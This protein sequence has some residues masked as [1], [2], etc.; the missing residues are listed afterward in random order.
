MGEE[1]SFQYL[2]ESDGT[3]ILPIVIDAEYPREGQGYK[4][5][6]SEYSRRIKRHCPRAE[7]SPPV[8]I[9]SINNANNPAEADQVAS[10]LVRAALKDFMGGETQVTHRVIAARMDIFKLRLRSVL[11]RFFERVEPHYHRL[12]GAEDAAVVKV[13]KQLLGSENTLRAGVRMRL[14]METVRPVPV[15]YFPYRILLTGMA[16]AAGAIDRLILAFSG[17]LPSLAIT[18][19]QT[20]RNLKHLHEMRANARTALRERAGEMVREELSE[21]NEIFLRSIEQE[22][23]LGERSRI[24][25]AASQ[26]ELSGLGLVESRSTDIFEQSFSRHAVGRWLPWLLGGMATLAFLGLAAAPAWSIYHEFFK[27]WQASFRDANPAI[28]QDFPAPSGSMIFAT[29]LLMTV[30]VIFIALITVVLSATPRRVNRCVNAIIGA[31]EQ[32]QDDLLR[33]RA[34][35]V[36]TT[37]PVRE[38]VRTLLDA[39]PTPQD[40]SQG[41][42]HEIDEGIPEN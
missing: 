31:H 4:D 30:P 1:S 35:R 16:L 23:D 13:I 29:L 11:G 41:Y 15:I 9:P 33:T 28:W 8:V 20:S 27:A 10:E 18:A 36:T 24:R 34:L 7:V 39:C 25:G 17:N 21:T 12:Q 14:L 2:S 38:A 22:I 40:S 19:F 5:A 37:D 6:L 32:M 26:I 3:R 42:S